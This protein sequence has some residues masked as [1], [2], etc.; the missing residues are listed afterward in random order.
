MAIDN[1]IFNHIRHLKFKFTTKNASL[2][3]F[4]NKKVLENSAHKVKAFSPN[5]CDVICWR[6]LTQGI[7]NRGNVSIRLSTRFFRFL[8]GCWYCEKIIL[9]FR[10]TTY[11]SRYSFVACN[12]RYALYSLPYLDSSS[13]NCLM[14]L[15]SSRETRLPFPEDAILLRNSS[16][17]LVVS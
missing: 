8:I 16:K 12:S 6:S 10:E 14:K 9:F 1:W 11:S 13:L 4:E 3:I 5:V 15:V 7:L 17:K 2:A